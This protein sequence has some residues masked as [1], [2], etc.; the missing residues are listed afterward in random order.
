MGCNPN[1]EAPQARRGAVLSSGPDVPIPIPGPQLVT[2]LLHPTL[3]PVPV[4]WSVEE[5]ADKLEA[6]SL[7]G[8]GIHIPYTDGSPMVY[9][10]SW[11]VQQTTGVAR[12]APQTPSQV[13]QARPGDIPVFP[14]PS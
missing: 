12:G 1:G 3:G 11:Q 5:T 7:G 4:P 9:L 8:E 2:V 10:P 6:A 14:K 13:I